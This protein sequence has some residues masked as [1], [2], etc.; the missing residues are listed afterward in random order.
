MNYIIICMTYV[1]L[2]Y[3]VSLSLS[4]LA[5]RK[6]HRRDSNVHISYICYNHFKLTISKYE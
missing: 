1:M 2:N 4:N 3:Q 6:V 5:E